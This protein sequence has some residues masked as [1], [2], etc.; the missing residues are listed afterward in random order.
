MRFSCCQLTWAIS[1]FRSLDTFQGLSALHCS[2]HNSVLCALQA[3][4]VWLIEYLT[5]ADQ[6]C[7]PFSFWIKS[8]HNY[9]TLDFNNIYYVGRHSWRSWYN[10]RRGLLYLL[11]RSLLTV[12]PPSLSVMI[13]WQ[14]YDLLTVLWSTDSIMIYWQYYDLLTPLSSTHGSMI[15]SHDCLLHTVLSSNHGTVLY[16]QAAISSLDCLNWWNFVFNCRYLDG[17]DD[18]TELDR[19]LAGKFADK[20]KAVEMENMR[21]QQHNEW[22]LFVFC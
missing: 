6:V 8:I 3:A 12:S 19:E 5:Y 21:F 4:L 11:H 22:V 14:C 13:Y 10:R 20:N 7:S 2:S 9:I 1:T 18:F 16:L 15:Y 17:Q